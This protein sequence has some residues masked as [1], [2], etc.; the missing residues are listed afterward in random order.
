MNLYEDKN[1]PYTFIYIS[2]EYYN[3][4]CLDENVF[5]IGQTKD[6]IKRLKEHNTKS[7]K[8]STKV[9]FELIYKV[10]NKPDHFFHNI[11]RQ[12]GFQNVEDK[13][14]IFKSS[15]TNLLTI[16]KIQAII[17]QQEYYGPWTINNEKIASVF[18]LSITNI[19]KNESELKEKL[20]SYA[21]P[22]SSNYNEKELITFLNN[23]SLLYD[24][25]HQSYK[26]LLPIQQWAFENNKIKYSQL[27]TELKHKSINIIRAIKNKE[28]NNT[29]FLNNNLI[30]DSDK[31]KILKELSEYNLAPILRLDDF[32]KHNHKEIKNLINNKI[33]LTITQELKTYLEEQTKL[34][35]LKPISSNINLPEITYLIKNNIII[36]EQLHQSF[37]NNTEIQKIAFLNNHLLYCDLSDNL[38]LDFYIIGQ[39]INKNQFHTQ[40]LINT[41]EDEYK[42]LQCLYQIAAFYNQPIELN[43]FTKNKISPIINALKN[44]IIKKQDLST[45]LSS[46]IFKKH[47][48][49]L[50][51]PKFIHNVNTPIQN[52]KAK[53]P[54]IKYSIN[55]SFFEYLKIIIPVLL[56]SLLATIG[57]IVFM[58]HYHD[59]I[60][61]ILEII[62]QTIGA[63][64]IIIC[65]IVF[66]TLKNPQ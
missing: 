23:K 55:L 6:P 20:N 11:L 61:N 48:Y 60:K 13:K 9:K 57:F 17:E 39:A 35:Y 2:R 40:Y 31:I 66:T 64:L 37:K 62:M 28:I 65:C 3:G 27:K 45:E 36:F 1:S 46:Y 4:K 14:E 7:S 25:I 21:Q 10:K 22:I 51:T 26:N 34:K 50:Y 42:I 44:N 18:S 8:T 19:I 56:I 29:D 30:P 32:T 52:A 47:K 59:T 15:K 63:V 33:K 54:H 12:K 49:E 16:E 58:N 5:G 43:D 41:N 53:I 38:K 24:Q